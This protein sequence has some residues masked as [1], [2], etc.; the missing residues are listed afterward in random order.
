[1]LFPMITLAILSVVGGFLQVNFGGGSLQNRLDNF[2]DPLLGPYQAEHHAS[3]DLKVTLALAGVGVAVLG[4][5]LALVVAKKSPLWPKSLEPSV[6]RRAWFVD[7]IYE[8]LFARPGRAFATFFSN[9]VDRL[10]VDG[11]VNGSARLVSL[12]GAG[13]RRAQSG[14][15][16]SYIVT[17]VGGTVLVLV[18]ALVRSNG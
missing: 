15:L 3:T 6:L 13:L 4:I 17:I 18:W 11:L 7:T 16:R 1:M 12:S 14:Y 10:L 8:W 5:L 9:V 2:L